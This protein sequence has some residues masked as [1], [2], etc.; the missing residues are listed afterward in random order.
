MNEKRKI[1]S[2]TDLDAWKNAHKLVLEI[3]KVTK[4]FPKEEIYGLTNQIRRCAI[5]IS[6]NISE[7]FSR[8]TNKDKIQ[9]YYIAKGSLA[10]MQNQLLV[11]RD[12]RLVNEQSFQD[13]ASLTVIVHKLIN[14]LIRSLNTK[15]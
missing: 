9:F 4:N 15:Y 10:E 12:L 11:G 14:G 13:L 7:G 1:K 5:S 2:F 3:Y 6:S 8:R